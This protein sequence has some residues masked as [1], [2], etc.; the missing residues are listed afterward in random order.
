[1][2]KF[3]YISPFRYTQYGELEELRK[4]SSETKTRSRAH[5]ILLS[6]EGFTI[7][8]LAEIFKVERDTISRWL[9]NWEQFGLEGL[10]D[11]ALRY[12]IPVLNKDEQNVLKKLIKENPRSS[13]MVAQKLFTQTGKN[14][15]HWTVKRLSKDLGLSWKRVRKSCK[16]ICSEKKFRKAKSELA[17][18]ERVAL[19]D[20]KKTPKKNGKPIT[21]ASES[22]RKIF[23]QIIDLDRII[24][25]EVPN[26]ANVVK[27]KNKVVAIQ[28][29]SSM[30]AV[31][32][33]IAQ[34]E[35]LSDEGIK[36]QIKVVATASSNRSSE[37]AFKKDAKPKARATQ[38]ASSKEAIL[39]NMV[40]SEELS[41]EG[42][43]PQNKVVVTQTASSTEAVLSKV[44]GRFDFPAKSSQVNENNKL[45]QLKSESQTVETKSVPNDEN[46]DPEIINYFNKNNNINDNATAKI[47]TE[48]SKVEI[49]NATNLNTNKSF[50]KNTFDIVYFDATGFDL[51]PSVPYAWQDKG[52]KN[53]ICVPSKRR[54]RINVLGFLDKIH[55]KLTP[56]VFE[57]T[58][59]TDVVVKIFDAFS[60]QIHNPTLV[61]M[62][63][64][65]IHTS[66]HFFNQIET[67]Q[68]KVCFLIFCQPFQKN[69]MP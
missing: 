37:V 65:S 47:G 23:K 57:E 24:I 44:A 13:K 4:S 58:I 62:D 6:S 19:T 28:S 15:S 51:I 50:N 46:K 32:S 14:I 29:A 56:F 12:R 22:D 36:S 69:L 38:T 21:K 34:F 42:I 20:A 49:G 10:Y 68:K 11:K 45:Y 33:K 43:K 63:N 55:Q 30:A 67:W 54:S 39:S 17:A 60:A 59:T 1:M 7:E 3:R 8:E 61:V 26:I 48:A 9:N 16:S 52:R 35:E 5:A 2:K 31:S 18:L 66:T 53:T 41:D 25:D 40:R 27:P 64:A